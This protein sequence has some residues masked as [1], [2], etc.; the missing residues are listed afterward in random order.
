MAR[1]GCLLLLL[2]ALAAGNARAATP[3]RVT[4]RLDKPDTVFDPKEA[5]G[6]GVDGHHQKETETI[7][8]P[9][10]Y[11]QMLST[12]LHPVSYRLRTEL[13]IEAW[14]WNPKGTWSDPQNKRGYWT[15]DAESKEPIQ[16][17][18]GYRLPRRGDTLDEANND[19]YSMID[20]G[21]PETFWKSNPYLD[22]HYT[23]EPEGSHPQ[24]VM[25]DFG[26][27]VP[28]NALRIHWAAPFATRFEVEYSSSHDTYY[29]GMTL[30]GVWH[31]FPHGTVT[32]GKGGAPVVKLA[33]RPIRAQYIRI[34]LLQ[35]SRTALEPGSTDVRDRLGYA[36]R[37]IEA[38]RLDS[39][40]ILRDAVVHH[41]NRQRQTMIYASSTDPWH[42]ESDLDPGVT[43]P[44][45]DL[46]ASSGL[47]RGLPLMIPIPVFY[48][49]PE[50]AAAEAAFLQ[51]RNYPVNRL[52][53]GEE[54]DGQRA[55]PRDFAALYLQVADRIR[56]V[57]PQATLGGPSF[58]SVEG[59]DPRTLTGFH[60]GLWIRAFMDY[61]KERNRLGDFQFLS[62][63]WYP[64][65]FSTKNPA[66][67]V[68]RVSRMLQ[69]AVR[70]LHA[71][72][73]PE[74]LPLLITE[75][76]YSAFACR[77]EVDISGA[78]LNTETAC[79]FLA[80]KGAASFLYGYEPGSLMDDWGNSWG[81][82][83]ILLLD[84]KGG[85]RAPTATY[86]A[87]RLLT[88]EWAHPGGG[89]HTL[90]PASIQTE[91]VS[92]YPVLRPDGRWAIMFLNKDPEKAFRVSLDF[93]KGNAARPSPFA[94]T[95]EALTFSS[96]QYEWKDLGANGHPVRSEPAAREV[97]HPKPGQP[98]FTLPP[99]SLTVLRSGTGQ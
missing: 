35:S 28:L 15:S 54:P 82:N 86:H 19:G 67:Q 98:A 34:R 42:R 25:V 5:L 41:P 62:F 58:V 1:T 76:G 43:Q 29:Y 6:A 4:V 52:E 92:A 79:Q 16:F 27:R 95:F 23:R 30:P 14:H 48:D 53:L 78:L 97:V 63:E 73:V 49:T 38:G 22:E 75:Y 64:F 84:G 32:D 18:Y 26:K 59:D 57:A 51:T 7:Y 45:F 40:G 21:D 11:R 47:T 36:I 88:R 44:G 91:K 99:W 17:S 70:L 68:A 89:A 10:I 80:Q 3:V 24:W 31:P 12:G 74:N 56:A 69:N 2:A 83:M 20:D 33:N 39:Q 55:S 65:D 9:E 37:E 8:S 96:R 60:R 61:L 77:A 72:G 66:P 90:Y 71:N 85:I 94:E 46:L 93:V 50:N 13:A 87:A 81:N